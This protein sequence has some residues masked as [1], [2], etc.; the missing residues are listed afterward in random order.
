MDCHESSLRST[1]PRN[2]GGGGR[3]FVA[4]INPQQK[5]TEVPKVRFSPNLRY[6]GGT[7]LTSRA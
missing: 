6:V 7:L 2:A 5:L 1:L 4:L 3:F